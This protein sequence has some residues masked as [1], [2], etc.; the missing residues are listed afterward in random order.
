MDTKTRDTL[1]T[2]YN[3]QGAPKDQQDALIEKIGGLI[4]QSVLLRIAPSMNDEQ[5]TKLETLLDNNATPEELIAFLKTI[6]PRFDDV[7][8]QEA[9]NFKQESDA[10]MSQIG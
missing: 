5:Q 2:A 9:A 4:F 1:I 8:A 3:L 7:V 6:E 10:I